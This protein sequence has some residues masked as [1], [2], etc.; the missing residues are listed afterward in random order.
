MANQ[1]RCDDTSTQVAAE[2]ARFFCSLSLRRRERVGVRVGRMPVPP[3]PALSPS[4]G[5][6]HSAIRVLDILQP[7]LKSQVCL[8]DVW[9]ALE[10]GRGPREHD[11]AVLEDVA[12]RGE[13]KGR[14]HVLL[15]EKDGRAFGMH[16]PDRVHEG[17]Q[18]FVSGGSAKA[19]ELL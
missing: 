10:L 16:F 1:P 6:G 11:L 18:L 12:R 5:E 2:M 8:L 15:D 14:G 19:G 4:G 13:V 3:H 17:I 9:I 7:W